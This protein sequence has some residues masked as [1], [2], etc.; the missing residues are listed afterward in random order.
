VEGNEREDVSTRHRFISFNLIYG[1]GN[2]TVLKKSSPPPYSTEGLG[3][4][5]KYQKR[6][7]TVGTTGKFCGSLFLFTCRPSKILKRLRES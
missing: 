4:K 3:G 6:K 7:E 2:G 1:K 5:G